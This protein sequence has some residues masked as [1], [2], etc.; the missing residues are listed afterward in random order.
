[1]SKDRHKHTTDTD[2][3]VENCFSCNNCCNCDDDC[4]DD[5]EQKY[6]RITYRRYAEVEPDLIEFRFLSSP[7]IFQFKTI[8]MRLA[9]ALGYTD[10]SIK[11]AFGAE[12]D[13][14]SYKEEDILRKWCDCNCNDDC[15]CSNGCVDQPMADKNDTFNHND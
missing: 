14:Y 9:A 8:C 6:E 13:G 15:S 3:D 4:K 11:G 12:D 2:N 10:E 5:L 7:D 1:M